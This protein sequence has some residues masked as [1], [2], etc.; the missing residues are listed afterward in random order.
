MVAVASLM[1]TDFFIV[2]ILALTAFTVAVSPKIKLPPTVGLVL[3]GLLLNI[4]GVWH[5]SLNP[6]LVFYVLLPIVIFEASFN[7]T[8]HDFLADWPRTVFLAFPGV[9]VMCVIVGFGV[10]LLGQPWAVA[11]MFAAIVAATDPVSVVAM[12]RD[13]GVAPRLRTII[14]S[15]SIMNDGTGAVAYAVV[16][17]I[18]LGQDAGVGWAA[19]KLTWMVLAGMAIGT[20]FALGTLALLRLFHDWNSW[21][22]VLTMS[23]ILAYGSFIM[24]QRVGAS[25]VLAAMMAGFIMGNYGHHGKIHEEWHGV[26]TQFWEYGA[27]FVNGLVFLL[28]GLIVDWR[29]VGRHI[30][31]VLAAFA[32]TLVARAVIVYGWD[33][34]ARAVRLGPVPRR[35]NHVLWWGGLRGTVPVA[36][37]LTVPKD[38]PGLP[39][40]EALVLGTVMASLI[41]EGTTIPPLVGK[42]KLLGTHPGHGP[43]ASQTASGPDEA[44]AAGE[45]APIDSTAH[46]LP[47]PEPERHS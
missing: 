20:V 4:T 30:G 9:G 39:M 22:T 6:D 37:L 19:G 27:F 1:N 2:L 46:D 28:V 13:L 44:V 16:L 25:G 31:L 3:V 41:I 38:F 45:K 15:E 14:E 21:H 47:D 17:A 35:W 43:L 36:L 34:F 23:M 18:L 40:I 33:F 29:V 5:A 26:L 8:T 7:L 24:A 32:F 11:F 42:L 10:H 12:F